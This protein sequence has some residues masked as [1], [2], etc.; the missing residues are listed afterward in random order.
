MSDCMEKGKPA[1]TG[2]NE[3]ALEKHANILVEKV[4]FQ[5]VVI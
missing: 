5:S 2:V 3:P 1:H 4:K